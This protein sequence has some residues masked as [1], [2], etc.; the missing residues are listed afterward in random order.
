MRVNVW[1]W[2]FVIF[3]PDLTQIL[4]FRVRLVEKIIQNLHAKMFFAFQNVTSVNMNVVQGVLILFAWHF[5]SID[6]DNSFRFP[7][8]SSSYLWQLRKEEDAGRKSVECPVCFKIFS[9]KSNLKQ[10]LR[11]VHQK[12]RPFKCVTCGRTFTQMRDMKEHAK[13]IHHRAS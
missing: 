3:L 13:R 2:M 1:F 5:S 11:S 6:Y 7:N 12:L 9:K 10:H 4:F 8:I